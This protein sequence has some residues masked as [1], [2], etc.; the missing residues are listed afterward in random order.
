MEGNITN[1]KISE[2]KLKYK[3]IIRNTISIYL[4]LA[5]IIF[6]ILSSTID[7]IPLI[8]V[9]IILIISDVI[10]MVLINDKIKILKNLISKYCPKCDTASIV[11]VRTAKQKTGV[12]KTDYVTRPGLMLKKGLAR[13]INYYRC[14]N[15]GYE[16]ETQNINNES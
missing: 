10:F 12:I 5:S 8:A 14:T 7:S 2:N 15:C 4:I 6:F 3:V 13:E 9:G 1:K 11:Y 16:H